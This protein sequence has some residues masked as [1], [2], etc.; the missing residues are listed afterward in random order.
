MQGET[1]INFLFD[2]K[3]D[4]ILCVKRKEDQ[5]LK[6]EEEERT[7]HRTSDIE[8]KEE[9]KIIVVEDPQPIVEG[10]LRDYGG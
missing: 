1:S 10:L 9:P 2:S 3:L 5:L 8:P 7:G 4:R 6:H